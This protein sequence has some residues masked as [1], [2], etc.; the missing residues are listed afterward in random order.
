MGIKFMGVWNWIRVRWVRGWCLVECYYWIGLLWE[1]A[2]VRPFILW[3]ADDGLL[4][5]EDKTAC[6]DH[7]PR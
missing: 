5:S 3:S 6:P 7:S 2:G 4:R 1:R